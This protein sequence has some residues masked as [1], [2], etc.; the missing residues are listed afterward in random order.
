[1]DKNFENIFG[2]SSTSD[3]KEKKQ[4]VRK[5]INKKNQDGYTALHMAAFKG[6]IVSR[7]IFFKKQKNTFYNF[8][9]SL[10]SLKKTGEI[11]QC[12][13]S[14]VLKIKK[15]TIF[16]ILF[17]IK[18]AFGTLTPLIFLFFINYIHKNL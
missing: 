7:F 4:I 6:N 11:S 17:K 3:Q 2:A 16:F 15:F 10:E 18:K 1:L 12:A 8:R 5:W 9:I 14:T 13:T